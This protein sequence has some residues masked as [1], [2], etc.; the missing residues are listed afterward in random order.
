VFTVLCKGPLGTSVQVEAM[1]G[2]ERGCFLSPLSHSGSA[3]AEARWNLQ[4]ARFSAL[5]G[6]RMVC[7]IEALAPACSHARC[8]LLSLFS[9]VTSHLTVLG[10]LGTST[11]AGIH[12]VI[13]R[14]WGRSAGCPLGCPHPV[15]ASCFLCNVTSC[16]HFALLSFP[17]WRSVWLSVNSGGLIREEMTKP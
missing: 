3:G 12:L 17:S 8:V 4:R 10:A 5:S 14:A 11:L 1:A 9:P 13:H 6:D 15:G 7:V 2:M 16:V